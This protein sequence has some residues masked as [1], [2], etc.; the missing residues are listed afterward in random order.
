MNADEV[1]AALQQRGKPQTAAI[2]RRH[3]SGDDVCG[4]LTS[5]L[6]KLRK[7]I[8]TDHD[9][10]MELW[11]TG[12]AEARILALQVADPRRITT[13]DA[14]R[15]IREGQVRFLACYLSALIAHAPIADRTMRAWMRSRDESK[16]EVGYGILGV[17]LKDSPDSIPDSYAE[18]VLATI[19]REIHGSP[20]RAR[21][22]MNGALI[23]IGVFKPSLERKAIEAA[24]RIGRVQVDH[25]ETGCTTPDAASYI[26][27]ASTRRTAARP[28]GEPPRA[29][30]TPVGSRYPISATS[31]RVM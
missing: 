17:R 27:K 29:A 1:L 16:R 10:A 19:E 26:R 15:L 13:A 22:A 11:R 30:A 9:L 14:D 7:K 28:P 18:E 20:N 24:T 23:S 6:G 5:E 21:Y 25:G 12:N 3:G 31:P 2:Y 4:V 8:R